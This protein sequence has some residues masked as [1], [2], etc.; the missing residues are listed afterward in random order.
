MWAGRDVAAVASFAILIAALARGS[1]LSGRFLATPLVHWL[2]VI[3][4]SIYLL[5]I[6]VWRG[7]RL[8]VEHLMAST[9]VPHAP[10][11]TRAV[12]VVVV[13]IVADISYRLIER[14]ARNA[15]RRLDPMRDVPRNRKRGDRTEALRRAP[16]RRPRENLIR[17]TRTRCATSR[18][19]A[20]AS[21]PG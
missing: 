20:G 11:V 8:P 14:P 19:Q 4:Y 18:D 15:V 5:Q 12:I 1:S 17:S 13:I 2:G 21:L 16:M 3:S 6:T 7:L 10:S 9:G